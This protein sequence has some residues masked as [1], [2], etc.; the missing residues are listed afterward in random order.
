MSYEPWKTEPNEETFEASGLKCQVRR[1]PR[2][3]H[4]CGYVGVPDSHPWFRKG[5]SDSVVAPRELIERPIDVDKVGAINVFCAAFKGVDF[6]EACEIVLLVDAHGGLTY[7]EE[8]NGE[9]A[10]LW[11]FGF[12]CAHAGDLCPLSA[13]RYGS[14]DGDVYR[15]FAYVKAETV[16]LARQLAAVAAPAAA[17]GA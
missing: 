17:A 12:D 10:G 2:S 5:Y 8:G 4:L 6:A 3:G 11:V 16:S 14:C 9:L 13:E 1:M 7:S 15:D